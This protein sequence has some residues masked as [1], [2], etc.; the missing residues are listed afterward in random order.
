LHKLGYLNFDEPFLKLRHQGLILAPDGEKMSKSKGNVINPDDLIAKYGAD[1]LRMY[2]MFMGPFDQAVAWDTNGVTGV[3]KF[4]ER[5]YKL[6]GERK[7]TLASE[8]NSIHRLVKKITEDIEGMKFNT[9][10]SSMM[11]FVNDMSRVQNGGW[12]ESFVQILAPF[13]PHLAEEMWQNILGKKQSVFASKWPTFDSTKIAHSTVV[14]AVQ[15]KGK[16]R[17]TVNLPVGASKE[18]VLEAVMQDE[19]LA[20][21]AK[22]AKKEIFVLN[23]IINFI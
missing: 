5:A 19:R 20:K 11:E 7:D 18:E 2:E 3:R 8:D 4:L 1:T 6:V 23:K 16:L 14:I 15:E 10:V 12:G 21:I 17:G 13:A 22:S 9:V